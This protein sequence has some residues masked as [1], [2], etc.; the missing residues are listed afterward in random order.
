[1]PALHSCTAGE[2]SLTCTNTV[3]HFSPHN[4]KLRTVNEFKGVQ[5]SY[6]P[7]PGERC[8]FLPFYDLK[9]KAGCRVKAGGTW[10]QY[11][12][13]ISVKGM[14]ALEKYEHS[15]LHKHFKLIPDDVFIVE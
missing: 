11:S 9:N 5:Y 13:I 6:L 15:H 7:S 3:L 12:H 1:M 8:I 14:F 10:S 4:V 2:A